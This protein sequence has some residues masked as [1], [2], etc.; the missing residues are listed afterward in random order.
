LEILD[1]AL[2][3]LRFPK[4]CGLDL[5]RNLSLMDGHWKKF[6]GEGSGQISIPGMRYLDPSIP[7]LLFRKK[8]AFDRTRN[9]YTPCPFGGDGQRRGVFTD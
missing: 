5:N 6:K 3:C 9:F 7:S 4:P 8:K 2:L 1:V